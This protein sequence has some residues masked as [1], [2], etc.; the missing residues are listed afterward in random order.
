MS[1]EMP[2]QGWKQKGTAGGAVGALVGGPPRGHRGLRSRL[3]WKC[4]GGLH[5]D[6]SGS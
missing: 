6:G 5:E 1:N 4:G 3:F 2:L